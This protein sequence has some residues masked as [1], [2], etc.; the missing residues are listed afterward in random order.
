MKALCL[1]DVRTAEVRD[2]P[3]PAAGSA[4]GALVADV[5]ACGVCGT[6][7][8]IWGHGSP[9]VQY[10]RVLGHEIVATVRSA[11]DSS[12]VGRRAVLAPPAL[13]CGECVYCLRGDA[14]LCVNRI[15]FGY[16]LDGGLAQRVVVPP[17]AAARVSAVP[18]PESMPSWLAA[19]AEPVSCCLNG[20]ERLG[21]ISDGWV[22]V[23]GAGIIGRT[24]ALLAKHA[25]AKVA[26]VDPDQSRL[27]D[28]GVDAAVCNADE[29]AAKRLTDI[30]GDDLAA[31]VVAASAPSVHDDAAAFVTP[32]TKVL[33]FAGSSDPA[34]GW[35]VNLIHYK[36]LEVVGSFAALPRHVEQAVE[37]LGGPLAP[38]AEDVQCIALDEVPAFLNGELAVDRPKVVVEL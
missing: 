34:K 32:R 29:P 3:E 25:G 14:N 24:H 33:L 35:S 30:V 7:R 18:V 26:V 28:I 19:L 12:L 37:L 9:R 10:P 20:Q 5:D 11:P 2:L 23:Y 6:D 38:L 16:E 4:D 27:G 21:E 36:E 17:S 22:V 15:A 31:V 8:R 1:S 13:P